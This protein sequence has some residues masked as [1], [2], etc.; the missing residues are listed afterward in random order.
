MS[1]TGFAA[2]IG[3]S[4]VALSRV[5]NEKAAVTAEMSI[6]ISEAFGQDSPI[7]GSISKTITTFGSVEREHPAEESRTASFCGGLIA[8]LTV[9][10]NVSPVLFGRGYTQKGRQVRRPFCFL[11]HF[12]K[13]IWQPRPPPAAYLAAPL[14]AARP[15]AARLQCGWRSAPSSPPSFPPS[16]PLPHPGGSRPRMM[17]VTPARRAARNFSLIPPTGSTLPLSVISPVMAVRGRTGVSV[18]S[19]ASTVAMVTPAEDHPWE[20][21][22]PARECAGRSPW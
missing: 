3:V 17:V 13:R 15:H 9:F 20:W 12:K 7:S 1:V 6:K 11:A 4:R 18:S 21:L 5:L 22:R 2:H 16:G 8:S 14:S 19:D 10:K